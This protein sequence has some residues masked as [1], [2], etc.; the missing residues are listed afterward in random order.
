[1][2]TKQGQSA[3]IISLV[4][5]IIFCMGMGYSYVV[6]DINSNK[7]K[8]YQVEVTNIKADVSPNSIAQV[9]NVSKSGSHADLKMSFHHVK[10]TIVYTVEVINSGSGDAMVETI[11]IEDKTISGEAQVPVSYAV[12]GLSQ[13]AIIK[14]GM[15]AT[16]TVTATYEMDGSIADNASV[17]KQAI[18][19]LNCKPA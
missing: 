6:K 17:V 11:D 12:E 15:S 10:D 8:D 19:S 13:G 2:K 4:C 14:S 3:V 16:F 5:A 1:M 9:L 7:N 18:I